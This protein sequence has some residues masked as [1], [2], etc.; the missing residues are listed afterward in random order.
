MLYRLIS[1]KFVLLLKWK[2]RIWSIL[3]FTHAIAVQLQVKLTHWVLVTHIR[4]GKLT[5]NGFDNGLSPE[6]RQAIIWTSAGIL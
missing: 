1:Q 4:I 5:I 2:I 6:R 3:N